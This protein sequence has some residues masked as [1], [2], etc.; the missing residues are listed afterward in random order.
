MFE[1][2]ARQR[3]LQRARIPSSIGYMV[4]AFLLAVGI[5][6]IVWWISSASGDE[7]PW[8][9]AVLAAGV[10]MLVAVAAREV[11]MRRAWARYVLE[12]EMG[13]EDANRHPTPRRQNSSRSASH[14]RRP[15][16]G[17]HAAAT[18]LRALQQRLAEAEAA[19][20]Q[21]PQAHLEA[22]RLC[23]QYLENIEKAMRAKNAAPDVRVALRAGQ[24]RVRELQKHHFLA[25]TRSE[26]QRLTTEARRRA[27]VSDKIETAQRAVEVID[28]ALKIY[29]EE[30][31]LRESAIAVRDFVAS[32]KVAHWVE[33]AD[34]AAFRGRY[35]R[36]IARYRDALFYVS[37]AEMGEE[38]RAD[39]ASRIM[40][41]I[42][43]LRARLATSERPVK[44]ISA[45]EKR[46][47]GPDSDKDSPPFM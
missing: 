6:F 7:S 19:G 15:S 22:Y 43:L 37:R 47:A 18:A 39:T 28:E 41:E 2:D 9:P 13:G 1:R 30:T 26:V 5:F 31:D 14:Q 24:E 11:V 16:D 12:M 38:A 4:S 46:E 17:V 42:E 44:N 33:L 10:I 40:R 25:W 36:A 45:R 20:A 29:P 27:R 32:V 8:L 35:A 23:G 21:Q 3:A 34:R